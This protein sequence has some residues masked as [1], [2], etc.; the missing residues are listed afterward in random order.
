MLTALKEAEQALSTYANELDRNAALQRAANDAGAAYKLAQ[1]RFNAGSQ[2][3]LDLLTT[4]QT[5]VSAQSALAASNETVAADQIQLFK[6]LG[7]GWGA[8]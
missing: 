7:G 4:E 3:E 8:S 2:S 1:V 6:A 5:L